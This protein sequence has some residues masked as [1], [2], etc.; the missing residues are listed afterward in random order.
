MP[1]RP[2]SHQ[3]EDISRSRLHR[4]FEEA[5]WTVEDLSKDYGEDLLVRIFEN[6]SATPL[7]FFV[8][9][10]ATDNLSRYRDENSNF[11]RYPVKSEHL[12]HWNR[13]QEPVLL[14]LW[15]SQSDK[16]FWTFV[17]HVFAQL[18]ATC[19][20]KERKTIKIP[21]SCDDLID[22]E[23]LHRIQ[24]LTK[25][26][27]ARLEHESEGAE[28][29]V[30]ML[31]DAIG[32]KIEYSPNGILI[33]EKATDQ[34]EAILFGDLAERFDQAA[35]NRNITHEEALKLALDLFIKE[36]EEYLKTGKFPVRNLRTGEVEYRQMSNEELDR[37]LQA[38]SGY[39][40]KTI[41]RD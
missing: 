22:S 6:G 16:T 41:K 39:C 38:E 33:T 10:K 20:L 25:A 14:T 36:F 17:Q 15:E 19:D 12:A 40:D 9:A 32:G 30:E 27:Y 3:L 21:I 34:V 8:Q 26:R 4:I 7:S 2:R 11:I 24:S 23:G 37:Y 13:F 18:H 5:G 31:R 29:L 28:F 35:A 1:K